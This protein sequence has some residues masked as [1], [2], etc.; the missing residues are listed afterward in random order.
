MNCAECNPLL[1]PYAD[2]ELDLINSLSIEQHL[3]SCPACAELVQQVQSIHLALQNPQ[4]SNEAPTGLRRKIAQATRA[5]GEHRRTLWSWNVPSFAFGG[6]CAAMLILLGMQVIPFPIRNSADDIVAS[7]VRSL[8]ADHLVDVASADSHTVKP[9]F[10]GKLDFTVPA[11]D[12]AAEG[13][14]LVGGRLEYLHDHTAAALVYK[15]GHHT[16]N[17]FIW[18]SQTTNDTSI[19]LAAERGFSI[20]EREANGLHFVA[21]S[22]LNREELSQLLMLLTR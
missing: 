5:S 18:P 3:K 1:A 8:M 9:W 6:V 15:R 14:P 7:H 22:D 12:F 21:V 10:S 13:F 4:L 20:V 17:V 11:R 2:R 16:V 19:R